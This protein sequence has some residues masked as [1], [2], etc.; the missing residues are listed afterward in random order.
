MRQMCFVNGENLVKDPYSEL[1]TLENCLGLRRFIQLRHF[2]FSKAKGFYCPVDLQGRPSCLSATKGRTHPKIANEVERRL[3]E[4]YRPFN[5]QL[6]NLTG[7]N[8]K[9]T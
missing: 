4:F 2:F 5:Q 1:K 7:V 8:Y 3:R 9:W 6:Y